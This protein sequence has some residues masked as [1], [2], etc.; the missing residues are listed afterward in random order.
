[1]L[2][3]FQ[4]WFKRH[5][6]D[7]QIIIL[8]FLLLSS[9]LT[10]LFFGSM[11]IPVFFSIMIAYLL[12]GIIKRL[13]QF[14]IQRKASVIIVTTLF[15]T[16][17]TLTLIG[18]LPL[19]AKQVAMFV[20]E[21]PSMLGKGQK[22][23]SNLFEQYPEL[24]DKFQ[25]DAFTSAIAA[26]LTNQSQQLISFSLASV[27]SFITLIVY[28]VLVPL[29]VFFFL[30]DKAT[31]LNWLAAFLP[32]D[33]E[34]STKV[35]KEVN[36]QIANYVRGKIWEILFIWGICYSTFALF[37]LKFTL[38]ISFFVGLSVIIPYIGA[39]ILVLPIALVAFF[40]WGFVAKSAYVIGAYGIIQALDGNL[41]SPLLLSEVVDLHPVAIIVSVLIFGGLWGV[42]GLFLAI[43]LATI[44]QAVI[45]A[46]RSM[47]TTRDTPEIES[48]G[49]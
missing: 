23:L 12:E 28:L 47:G 42:W 34:L 48:S 45:K 6:S 33:L 43:P 36:L 5:F 11:L 3:L 15:V 31:I 16:C 22:S 21:L 35:W 37:E 1:M 46:W 27:R 24:I 9:F 44:V 19:L 20:Q 49:Q 38:L 41:I 10:I 14:K 30:K 39:T 2:A 26:E 13:E 18:L 29:L 40:Q 32:D 4:T 8:I 25:I 7:P 17:L